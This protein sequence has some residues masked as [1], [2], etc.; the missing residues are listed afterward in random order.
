MNENMYLNRVIQENI[1]KLREKGHI[2]IE[3]ET[4]E[5]ACKE[6]GIGR[7]ASIEKI[8]DYINNFLNYQEE[9]KGKKILVTAGRTEEQIDPVRYISNYSTGKMG[10][11]IAEE[12]ILMGAEVT[13]IS[14]PTYLKP[15]HSIKY[16]PVKTAEEI[17]KTEEVGV[18]KITPFPVYYA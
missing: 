3:P 1:K 6:E 16:I 9:F 2:I 13:L 8:I 11:S 10:F 7:L 17:A 14:G 12:A 5:L 18:D 4:G 15:P